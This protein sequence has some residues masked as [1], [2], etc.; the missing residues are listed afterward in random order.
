MAQKKGNSAYVEVIDRSDLL[1]SMERDLRIESS[2]TAVLTIEMTKRRLGDDAPLPPGVREG[3][4]TNTEILLKLARGKG[5]PVIHCMSS[6]RDVEAR[7]RSR[8]PF[9]RALV[10]SGESLSPYGPVHD[11]VMSIRDGTFKPDLVVSRAKDDYIVRS[12]KGLSCFY[13]TDL[14][15]LLRQLK[16]EWVVLAGVSTN[17]DVLATAYELTNR[18]LG[19]I[20]IKDCVAS[21]YGEDLHELGLQQLA[22][23]QGWVI[24]LDALEG[25]LRG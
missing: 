25:K 4:L 5:I 23:C 24:G 6:L 3:L 22:R 18:N 21:T 2:K 17:A 14:E 9:A 8:M 20:T 7:A 16:R 19:A 13:A 11:E 15:W 12:K 1:S 10:K